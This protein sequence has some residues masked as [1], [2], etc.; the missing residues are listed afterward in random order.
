MAHSQIEMT[1]QHLNLKEETVAV[2]TLV[3]VVAAVVVA[4]VAVVGETF[5]TNRRPRCTR[6][7][8]GMSNGSRNMVHLLK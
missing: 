3:V 1:S 8:V 5:P 6:F 4:V 7:I 2:M